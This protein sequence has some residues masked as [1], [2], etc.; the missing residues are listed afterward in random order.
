MCALS[1]IIVLS[2]GLNSFDTDQLTSFTP[3]GGSAIDANTLTNTVGDAS[4]ENINGGSYLIGNLIGGS[5]TNVNNQCTAKTI[6]T[7]S[8]TKGIC[9]EVPS[10]EGGYGITGL[11]YAP[12]TIDLRPGYATLRNTRWGDNP[13]TVAIDPIN[14]DWALRQPMNTYAVQLGETLPSFSPATGVNL[15]PA[16]QANSDGNA[17]AWTTSSTGWRN[18]SMT[19][20][21]VEEKCRYGIS[22]HRY[23]SQD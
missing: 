21:V 18:C 19:N 20:L 3:S 11:A 9:P 1:S 14:A 22:G 6:S 5:G 10:T 13:S 7:L 8:S 4:H 16:C 23:Y 2:T 17:S 15:V 12:K